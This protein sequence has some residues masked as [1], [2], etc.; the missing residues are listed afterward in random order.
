MQ[1][2]TRSKTIDLKYQIYVI[3]LTIP[4]APRSKASLRSFIAVVNSENCCCQQRNDKYCC[5]FKKKTVDLK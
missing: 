2:K 5:Q 1:N 3:F 4:N